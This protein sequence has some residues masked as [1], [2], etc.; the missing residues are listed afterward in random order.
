[1]L[2]GLDRILNGNAFGS[3]GGGW[4]LSQNALPSPQQWEPLE[5]FRQR[6]DM[7][8]VLKGSF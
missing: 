7:I 2:R 1:M 3:L 6:S 4:I 8:Y 5:G